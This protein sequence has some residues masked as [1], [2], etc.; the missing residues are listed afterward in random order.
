M[1]CPASSPARKR[2]GTLNLP[3]WATCAASEAL[4]GQR[5]DI[6]YTGVGALCR[7][8]DIPR[9]AAVAASLIRPGGFLYLAEFHPFGD[10]LDEADG[11]TVAHD[12]F[13]RRPQVDDA[14]GSYADRGAPIAANTTVQ[15]QHGLGEI[16]TALA[17]TGL[18]VEFVHEHDVSLFAGFHTMTETR[19]ISDCWATSRASR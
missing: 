4:G 13:D 11:R 14:T 18:R 3:R 5:Y 16:I 12:Y 1:T 10:I 19:G 7:L 15:W 17:A 8:P 9:W 6:V 2:C